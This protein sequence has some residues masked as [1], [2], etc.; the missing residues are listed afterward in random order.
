M[1]KKKKSKKDNLKKTVESFNNATKEQKE[2]FFNALE[3]ALNFNP[4]KK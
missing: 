1:P 4:K 3:K 2:E